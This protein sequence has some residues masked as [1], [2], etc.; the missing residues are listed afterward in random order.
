MTSPRVALIPFMRRKGELYVGLID[1]P[2]S[3]NNVSR[4]R[5]VCGNEFAQLRKEIAEKEIS[6]GDVSECKGEPMNN[7]LHVSSFEVASNVLARVE[8]ANFL[9]EKFYIFASVFQR[10][11]KKPN[12]LSRIRFVHWRHAI[13]N[14]TGAM[15]R[16]GIAQ[17]L[18]QK[19]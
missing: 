4:D 17:L 5:L 12:L 6:I 15:L 8:D 10:P 1:V 19:L 18:A 3:R 2:Q 16:A 9:S 13:L 11:D 14:N 7:G